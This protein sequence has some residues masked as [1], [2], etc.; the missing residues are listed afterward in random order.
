MNNSKRN[1]NLILDLT[2]LKRIS[3]KNHGV[4]RRRRRQRRREDEKED[5]R[6]MRR[7]EKGEQKFRSF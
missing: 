1:E 3:K 4:G 7:R 5:K 2:S 6:R